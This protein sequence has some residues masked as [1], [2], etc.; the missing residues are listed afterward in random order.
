M[1]TTT[2]LLRAAA[3]ALLAFLFVYMALMVVLAFRARHTP[4]GPK[5]PLRWYFIVPARDEEL[6]IRNTVD[7]L[8]ALEHEH[9]RVLV[10]DDAS[11]DRTAELVG[12]YA[13]PRLRL[14]SRR[15][16][17]ARTGKGDVL[18]HAYRVIREEVCAHGV[19]PDSTIVAV[20]DADGRL[21]ADALRHVEPSF[22]DPEVGGVQVQVRIMNRGHGWLTRCQ[23]F[24]FLTFSSL[25]QTARE[26]LG[27]V[28]LGGNGQFVRLSAL[29]SLGARPWTDCL[30]E[31]L[32][33]GLRLV[34]NGWQNRFVGS[35]RVDQQGVVGIRPVI[36]QRTRWMQGHLQCWRRIPSILASPRVATRTAMDLCWYLAAPLLTVLVS[37][38][39]GLPA[40][41]LMVRLVLDSRSGGIGF[42]ATGLA[43]IYALSFGP[44]WIFAF[45]YRHQSKD[46]GVIRTMV[47]A[48][49]I[50][51][52]NYVWYVATWR[53]VC[54]T[55]LR[56]RQWAKTAR[57]PEYVVAGVR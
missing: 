12:A 55:L 44:S 28:G 56:R 40:L 23:D 5:R 29:S 43:V 11:S 1:S 3:V 54:R 19:A 30:T 53:A 34:L 7:S 26:H 47:M 35:T 21:P 14:I 22:G 24:E 48:H 13:D 52:Y 8:L 38:I 33:L 50:A 51:V 49:V 31:D 41:I 39:F 27:S 18:N 20:V 57:H 16:P 15:L 6:V 10:V 36:R 2:E 42:S 17:E 32:D 9:V 45:L 37:V 46:V 25:M 4:I